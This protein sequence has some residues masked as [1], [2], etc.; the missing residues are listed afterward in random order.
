[1]KLKLIIAA[2]L[3]SHQAFADV[4]LKVKPN[5]AST[6]KNQSIGSF[7]DFEV[8]IHNTTKETQV[9][10]YGAT[11]CPENN[12]CEVQNRNTIKVLPND[13]FLQIFR[14]GTMVQYRRIGYFFNKATLTVNGFEHAEKIETGYITV[15]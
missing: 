9:Y 14:L 7:A 10:S 2:M 15:N 1:M 8:K 6:F 3:L 11:Q 12:K 5:S 4:S 13:T